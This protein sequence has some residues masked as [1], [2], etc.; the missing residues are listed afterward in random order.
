ML[1]LDT[2]VLVCVAEAIHSLARLG[3]R[4]QGKGKWH[5]Q[6]GEMP[7]LLLY[8]CPGSSWGQV[9]L[10]W[11]KLWES[12][13]LSGSV[14]GL[15]TD[16]LKWW[17]NSHTP[18]CLLNGILYIVLGWVVSN[19]RCFLLLWPEMPQLHEKGLVGTAPYVTDDHNFPYRGQTEAWSWKQAKLL[20][21]LLGLR[22]SSLSSTF[23]GLLS[24]SMFRKKSE[25]CVHS[26]GNNFANL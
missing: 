4:L 10:W 9:S 23:P 25:L 18:V 15:V 24:L 8:H 20:L 2:Q 19:S 6:G 3:G 13:F 12:L 11:Q 26:I 1:Q 21:S 5:E 16:A 14:T 22:A 7:L 17:N